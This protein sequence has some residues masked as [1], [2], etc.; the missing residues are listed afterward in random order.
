MNEDDISVNNSTMKQYEFDFPNYAPFVLLLGPRGT[1]KGIMADHLIRGF[2]SCKMCSIRARA[3]GSGTSSEFAT[4]RW[5]STT[6]GRGRVG[7]ELILRPRSG[8]FLFHSEPTPGAS[9]GSVE[10]DH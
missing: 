8:R 6:A 7:L 5:T 2:D 9:E 4:N 10:G 1:G 3:T